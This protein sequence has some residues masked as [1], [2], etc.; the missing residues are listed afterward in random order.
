MVLKVFRDLLKMAFKM[1][2][3]NNKKTFCDRFL[4]VSPE[5]SRNDGH[6]TTPPGACFKCGKADSW[7]KNCPSPRPLPETCP[8][9]GQ[10]RP[11]GVDCLLCLDK[12][13]KSS[14]IP[15]PQESL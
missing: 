14:Q 8:N 7:V 9:C 15:P 2:N 10:A 11:W 1:F 12:I 5:I 13:S 6:R 3:N 4:A